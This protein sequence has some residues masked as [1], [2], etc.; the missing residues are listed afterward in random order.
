MSDFT[1]EAKE[2]SK[3]Y[4]GVEALKGFS[5]NLKG[6][7]IYG[8]F[9]RNGAGK[10]TFLDIIT[11]RI[12]ADSGEVSLFGKNAVENQDVLSNTCYMPEKNLFI[13][14][15]RVSEIL[16][17]AA[18]FYDKF[19]MGYAESLAEKF[20]LN[21]KKKYKAL[22]KGY[23]SI[24]RIV[25]G[26][27]SRASLTI[28]DEPVLGLDAAARDMFYRELIDDYTANPRAFIISTHLVEESAE[29][30]EEAIIIKEGELVAHMEV[31]K[32]KDKARYVSGRA[33]EVDQ[34]VA[35]LKV[36]H[37]ETVG[38]IKVCMVFDD[39]D[40]ERLEKMRSHGVDISPVSVQKIFIHLTEK[41][42]NSRKLPANGREGM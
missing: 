32:L 37:S 16:K 23:E 33:S 2:L 19:D 11:S 15:M 14:S 18:V 7:K 24:L 17:S 41:T 30:F 42:D 28:F 27:A 5:I 36:V 26:L 29:I 10:T 4:G 3:R 31:Y 22:S 21:L 8:L 1:L 38:N 9:G 25:I 40:E 6:N 13:T 20:G 34:A 12:F 39:L 35:G